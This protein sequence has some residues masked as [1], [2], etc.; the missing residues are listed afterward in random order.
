MVGVERSPYQVNLSP[1]LPTGIVFSIMRNKRGNYV[2]RLIF[3][4][5]GEGNLIIGT[6][7]NPMSSLNKWRP[8]FKAHKL[9]STI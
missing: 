8:F 3:R 7:R 9:Q 2:G 1:V 5:S 4:I 6:G